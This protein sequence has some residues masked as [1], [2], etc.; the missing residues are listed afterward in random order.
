MG[1]PVLAGRHAR[2]LFELAHE[3][4]LIVIP[5]ECRQGEDSHLRDAQIELRVP[6]PG[7]DDVLDTGGVEELLIQMLKM[8]YAQVEPLGQP[9]RV[10]FLPGSVLDF[11]AQL[12]HGVIVGIARIVI[13]SRVHLVG[14]GI[15]Q[16]MH[17]GIDRLR[18]VGAGRQL[19]LHHQ[20][21]VIRQRPETGER[22]GAVHRNCKFA[23]EPF[24]LPQQLEMDPV[25]IVMGIPA[26]IMHRRTRAVDH[27]RVGPEIRRFAINLKIGRCLDE[28]QGMI[29]V[30]AGTGTVELH[31]VH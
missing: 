3:V 5:A 11:H 23:Q 2:D 6:D 27:H 26:A 16:G 1:L 12:A 29:L 18:A 10:P 25:V 22:K 31:L 28:Q 4:Q 17:Q 20:S 14:Q 30:A 7:P 8:G 19:F 24:V 9:G 15:K 13:G 21:G